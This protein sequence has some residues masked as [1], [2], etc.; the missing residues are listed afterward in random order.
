M[1]LV[2]RHPQRGPAPLSTCWLAERSQPPLLPP[3]GA[4]DAQPLLELVHRERRRLAQAAVAVELLVLRVG[5]A[6][7]GVQVEVVHL[8]SYA[9]R[10]ICLSSPPLASYQGR[11]GTF[12]LRVWGAGGR[13]G[14]S[15][16]VA[17][18]HRLIDPE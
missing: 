4:R 14:G 17:A 3:L 1:G 18:V 2:V 12:G 5:R 16:S 11:M 7:L 6:R 10:Y 8:Q 13:G 9:R 15:G